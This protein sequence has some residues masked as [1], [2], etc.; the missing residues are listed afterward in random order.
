MTAE[1]EVKLDLEIQET[2]ADAE[3]LDQLTVFLAGELNQLGVDWARPSAGSA[4]P[5]AKGDP[6]AL[7]ALVISVLPNLAPKLVEFLQA[8]VMRGEN[9][10]VKIKTPAGLEIEF[11]PEKKLAKDEY[12]TLVE[13]LVQTHS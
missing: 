5:G 13:K 11:T 2:D 7:G 8:W 4:P 9:R 12:L 1:P 3:R 10:K 6:I